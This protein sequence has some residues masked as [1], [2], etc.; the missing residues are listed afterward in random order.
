MVGRLRDSLSTFQR[1]H[2]SLKS[3]DE[4][5]PSRF[6]RVGQA[7]ATRQ[8][9]SGRR[10]K[11]LAEAAPPTSVVIDLCYSIAYDLYL[12]TISNVLYSDIRADGP[13]YG[14]FACKPLVRK[15]QLAHT[16][17]SYLHAAR[18]ANGASAFD[19]A[20]A[21]AF[22]DEVAGCLGTVELPRSTTHG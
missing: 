17:R 18:S 8:L 19:A 15:Q 14:L 13:T 16:P 22:L 21:L 11:I 10:R 5:D 7:R 9:R 2:R 4:Y 1:R 3:L 12:R 20:S 6:T